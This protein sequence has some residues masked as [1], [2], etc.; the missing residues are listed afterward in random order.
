VPAVIVEKESQMRNLNYAEP[1][2]TL[3]R[4]D[5]AYRHE[6]ISALAP[7]Y[8]RGIPAAVWWQAMRPRSRPVAIPAAA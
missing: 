8:Y 6:G 4:H 2:R 1:T 7:S 3:Y 5:G